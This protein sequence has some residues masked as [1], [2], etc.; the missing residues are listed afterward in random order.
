MAFNRAANYGNLPNGNFSPVVFSKKA[1]LAFRKKAVANDITNSDYWGEI[2]SFGDTVRV[3]KEP[4][5][6]AVLQ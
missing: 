2:S 5:F 4:K 3:M 1:Q 6:W